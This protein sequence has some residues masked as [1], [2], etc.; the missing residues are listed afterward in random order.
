MSK[1]IVDGNLRQSNLLQSFAS[2]WRQMDN[3]QAHQELCLP[4]HQMDWTARQGRQDCSHVSLVD[5][6]N[7][8]DSASLEVAFSN[9]AWLVS[10]EL[11]GN[12][13]WLRIVRAYDQVRAL[14]RIDSQ[15]VKG[16]LA[17][18]SINLAHHSQLAVG[19]LVK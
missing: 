10:F 14:S 11:K 15:N 9:G 5:A 1:V 16:H 17:S 4:V 6:D 2:Q 7:G 13:Q 19:H 3:G 8:P 18:L 12:P